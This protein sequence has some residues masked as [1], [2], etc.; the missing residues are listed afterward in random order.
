[1]AQEPSAIHF[2]DIPL[3]EARTMGRGPRT[4]PTR[5]AQGIMTGIGFLGAGVIYKEGVQSASEQILVANSRR[6]L[7][8]SSGTGVKGLTFLQQMR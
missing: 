7:A 6:C 1:M 8:G 3:A 5:M 2:E 4:D